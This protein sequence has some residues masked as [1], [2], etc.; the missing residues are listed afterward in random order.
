MTFRRVNAAS[1]AYS[2]EVLNQ[3][4]AVMVMA[5]QR[6]GAALAIGLFLLGALSIARAQVPMNEGRG[7]A[8]IEGWPRSLPELLDDMGGRAPYLLPR[9]DSLALDYRYAVTDTSSRWSFVLAWRPAERILYEGEILPWRDGPSDIRMTN[10]EFSA[11]VRVDGEKV[12]EM[13]VG[14]DSMN[15]RPS[16]DRFV[17]NVSVGHDRVFLDTSPEQARRILNQGIT[18]DPLVVERMG[19][20]A[21]GVDRGGGR[22]GDVRPREPVPPRGPSVYTPR[23]NVLIGWRI[24]P[25]PYYIGKNG[26]RVARTERPRRGTVGQTTGGDEGEREEAGRRG[27]ETS[28]AGS[29]KTAGGRTSKGSSDDDDDD[30]DDPDLLVPAL[31]A[32][33]AVVAM[34]YVGGTVGLWGRGDTPIG[35]AAGRTM[36]RGGVQLQA[37]INAAVLE[38]DAG[39]QLTV[40][41]LG[42]YDL[43][44]GP[45]QPALGLG[46]HVDSRPDRTLRPAVSAGLV[47]NF[48]TVVLFGG[49]DVVQGTPEFG[50]SYNFRSGD[51]DASSGRRSVR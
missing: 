9:I 4:H 38:D 34:G 42:F 31:G 47:G 43:F 48:N 33:A 18:L 28:D 5:T 45:V 7:T 26:K 6:F 20:T 44:G 25:R 32:A 8:T 51:R 41:A 49:F 21:A 19:F 35:I 37:A 22:T 24:A 2:G 39:Q 40:K 30:E 29:G 50:L 14:V 10:V 15:L 23:T 3:S 1:V 13:I 27:E 17:F 12:A 46:V 36:P 16:P 11:N